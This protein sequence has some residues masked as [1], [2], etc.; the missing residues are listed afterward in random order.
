M[1]EGVGNCFCVIPGRKNPCIVPVPEGRTHPW[2][3]RGSPTTSLPQDPPPYPQLREGGG[4]QARPGDRARTRHWGTNGP[5]PRCRLNRWRRC[6]PLGSAGSRRMETLD[7][8]LT[9]FRAYASCRAKTLAGYSGTPRSPPW[10][11]RR[12]ASVGIWGQRLPSEGLS[13][14]P[15]VGGSGQSCDGDGDGSGIRGGGRRKYLTGRRSHT[16]SNFFLLC[17]VGC[18]P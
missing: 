10:E 11:A 3:V 17:G 9:P 12:S 6:P 5:R 15:F 8:N 7:P 16:G 2:E 1:R 18:G 4:G 14:S 13:H